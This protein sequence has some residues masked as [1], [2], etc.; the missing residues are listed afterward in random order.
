MIDKIG[1]FMVI[2]CL[3]FFEI[4]KNNGVNKIKLKNHLKFNHAEILILT[5][6]NEL[7]MV[8]PIEGAWNPNYWIA[9]WRAAVPGAKYIITNPIIA[10]NNGRI[11]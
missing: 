6:L 10:N 8:S 4:S 9:I 11:E 3:I 1:H 2:L 5:S 7:I